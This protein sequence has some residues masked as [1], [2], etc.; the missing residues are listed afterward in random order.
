MTGAALVLTVAILKILIKHD[1]I[2]KNTY[3]I[4]K[5]TVNIIIITIDLEY[6]GREFESRSL[7][8]KLETKLL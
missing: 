3:N 4:V 7:H 6:G 5:F 1:I 8:L 2:L